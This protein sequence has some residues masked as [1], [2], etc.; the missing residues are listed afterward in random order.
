VWTDD[1]EILSFKM[2]SLY[3]SCHKVKEKLIVYSENGV[4]LGYTYSVGIFLYFHPKD[5]IIY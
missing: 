2:C 1:I 5:K 3:Y 4:G